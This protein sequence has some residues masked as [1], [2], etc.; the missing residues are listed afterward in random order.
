M[1]MRIS[2]K[3]THVI[4]STGY[5]HR[6]LEMEPNC[7]EWND[8]DETDKLETMI[9]FLKHKNALYLHDRGEGLTIINPKK[10]SEIDAILTLL[11]IEFKKGLSG[12]IIFKTDSVSGALELGSRIKNYD[13]CRNFGLCDIEY[14]TNNDNIRIIVLEYD[15]E[16]G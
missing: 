7:I 12:Y 11:N 5:I 13:Y 8:D 6:L 16:S 9:E 10:Q 1:S 3:P 2:F 15:T 14:V 4:I